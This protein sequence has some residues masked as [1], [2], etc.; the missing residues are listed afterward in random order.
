MLTLG[1]AAR[2]RRLNPRMEVCTIT[3]I[4]RR[5]GKKYFW[6]DHD[7]EIFYPYRGHPAEK[8][9][10]PEGSIS[11]GA[12]RR[13]AGREVHNQTAR[14][15]IRS[16][17]FTN[18]DAVAGRWKG[19]RVTQLV[20]PWR[21]PSEEQIT[22]TRFFIGDCEWT[23]EEFEC[24]FVGIGSLLEVVQGILMKP[25]CRH[26][27]RFGAEFGNPGAVGCQYD[28]VGN[29]QYSIEIQSVDASRRFLTVVSGTLPSTADDF[30][31]HGHVF[32]VTGE[33]AGLPGARIKGYVDSTRTIELIHRP[34]CPVAAGEIINLAPGCSGTR[35]E[36]KGFGQ[37]LNFG[38]MDKL[39]T[40]EDLRSPGRGN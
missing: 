18:K 36:C 4:V 3:R 30:W 25:T 27:T 29:S 22:G 35:T 1:R 26:A 31:K 39:P 40:E 12:I 14:G 17:S 7:E 33:N 24:E 34:P 6:T 5:D 38:G 23:G 15:V 37:T 10:T 8:R 19:A 11:L 13:Q 2:D 16:D 9:Y 28:V 21:E 20:I 32:F